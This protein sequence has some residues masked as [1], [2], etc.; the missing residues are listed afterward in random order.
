MYIS[1]FNLRERKSPTAHYSIGIIIFTLFV[2][3]LLNLCIEF[4][5]FNYKIN[6]IIKVKF[7]HTG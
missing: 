1:Q 7:M 3:T 5:V 2:I 4:T 6:Y